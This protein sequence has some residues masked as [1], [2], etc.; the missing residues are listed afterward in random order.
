MPTPERLIS[1][2]D[3]ITRTTTA[4]PELREA[5]E[6][7][8]DLSRRATWPDAPSATE[9][10]VITCALCEDEDWWQETFGSAWEWARWFYCGPLGLD[11]PCCSGSAEPAV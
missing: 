8:R 11:C 9:E 5:A 10:A 2:L 6:K 7:V 3:A 1:Q 4:P